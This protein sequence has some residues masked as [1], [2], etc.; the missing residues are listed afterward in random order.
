MG[1][2]SIIEE[3]IGQDMDKHKWGDIMVTGHKILL[4]TGWLSWLL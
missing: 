1:R 2:W 3:R 4:D